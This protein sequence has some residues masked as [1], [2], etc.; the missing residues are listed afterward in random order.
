MGCP[1][2]RYR[3]TGRRTFFTVSSTSYKVCN[4]SQGKAHIQ[5]GLKRTSALY[6]GWDDNE[7]VALAFTAPSG[8]NIAPLLR[9]RGTGGP[10]GGRAMFN[11]PCRVQRCLYLFAKAEGSDPS[12]GIG[13]CIQQMTRL[14]RDL[15]GML[16]TLKIGGESRWRQGQLTF[17]SMKK[18]YRCQTLPRLLWLA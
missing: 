18:Y 7:Q 16:N 4:Q 3:S 5:R 6:N 10:L 1:P 2:T 17:C 12:P 9:R 13:Y 14:R 11:I 15:Q 8:V